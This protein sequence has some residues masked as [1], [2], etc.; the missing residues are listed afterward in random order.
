LI[1]FA[2][3]R[4]VDGQSGRI[5]AYHL[6]L[7]TDFP[8]LWKFSAFRLKQIQKELDMTKF[9]SSVLQ[10]LFV[11]LMVTS[12]PFTLPTERHA[13]RVRKQHCFGYT[14]VEAGKGVDCYGDTIS[15]VKRHGFYE[16]A[17]IRN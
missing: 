3:V 8:S 7:V 1:R 6:K 11:L 16:I 12:N 5:F 9:F 14:V 4:S 2:Y 10:L 17:S 15:L 13:A